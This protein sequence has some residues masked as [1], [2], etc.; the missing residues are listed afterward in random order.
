MKTWSLIQ[1]RR[2]WLAAILTLG[3]LFAGASAE[4]VTPGQQKLLAKRAAQ[5]DAYRKLTEMI[6]GLQISSTTMVRDFVAESDDVRTQFDHFIK[7][8]KVVGQPRYFDD[9]TC[10]VD[11]QVTLEQVMLA[12]ETIVKTGPWGDKYVIQDMVKY[13]RKKV[14]TAT[15]TGLPREEPEMAPEPAALPAP[16]PTR[17]IPGWEN[18]TPR[19][20][21]MAERAAKVD[22]YRNLA[23]TVMGLRISGS[24]TVR[25]FVAESD[26]IRTDLNT[27]LQ[28]AR[29]VGP[30]RYLPDA[31][32]EVDVEITVQDVIKHLQEL[33]QRWVTEGNNF[34][35]VEFRT[36]NFETIVGYYPPKIIKAVGNGTVPEKYMKGPAVQRR[37]AVSVDPAPAW[38]SQVVQATGTGVPK[39]GQM[40]AEAR[41]MAER[42][43]KVEAMRN[44]VEKVYGVQIDAKTT[45]RD[46]VTEDDSIQA[47]VKQTLAGAQ[48]VGEPRYL[49]DGS[50]EVTV[51]IPM[52]VIYVIYK[53][54]RNM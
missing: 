44:L 29:Q 20:R 36:T 27:F 35:I 8:L 24:T 47:R 7:G 21:L 38:A 32:A 45:V 50:V 3:F 13:N 42:A 22:A 46:F 40:G 12:L 5:V 39:D 11:V 26:V 33:Q 16:A 37:A 17:G 54:S 52:E 19:G 49:P 48:Q 2:G 6:M 53:E 51:Q 15:G 1:Q 43:A 30:A 18:V 14:F 4:A 34:R 23:E 9:G 28:G 41:L 25:D 10:E 31:I